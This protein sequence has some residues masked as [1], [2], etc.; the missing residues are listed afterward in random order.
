MTVTTDGRIVAAAGSGDKAGVIVLSPDGK[1]LAMIPTPEDPANVEF[2]GD[3]RQDALHL[4]RQEPVSDQDDHDR[5]P[6]LAAAEMTRGPGT[7][8]NDPPDC[9]AHRAP[10]VSFARSARLGT[11]RH[12]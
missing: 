2:G 8:P 9:A 11:T 3:R 7:L 5:V 12:L 1:I 6:A 10:R 4:R